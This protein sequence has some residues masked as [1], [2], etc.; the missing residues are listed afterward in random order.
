MDQTQFRL[1]FET[2]GKISEARILKFINGESK[3]CGFIKFISHNC[4]LN[5]IKGLNN[6]KIDN[7]KQDIA[8]RSNIYIYQ[9]PFTYTESDLTNLFRQFG[10]IIS[11]RIIRDKQTGR[12]KGYGFVQFDSSEAANAAIQRMDGY[13]VSALGKTQYGDP[14][15]QVRALKVQLKKE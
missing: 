14:L 8:L 13:V 15:Q 12:S 1:L 2:Y 9:I 3:C 7:P 10:K 11:T 6:V 5:A 4:A